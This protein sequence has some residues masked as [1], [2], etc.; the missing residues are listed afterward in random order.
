MEELHIAPVTQRQVKL[1][2]F[3]NSSYATFAR[4]SS[5]Q[6]PV[7]INCIQQNF[8]YFLFHGHYRHLCYVDYFLFVFLLRVQSPF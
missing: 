3:E 5:D 7:G 2:S 6:Q 1:C 4:F 8:L